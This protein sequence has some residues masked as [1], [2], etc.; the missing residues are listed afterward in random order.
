MAGS[1]KTRSEIA[2][3][4][5]HLADPS[6]TERMRRHA[7]GILIGIL[8][9]HAPGNAEGADDAAAIVE[10]ALP[11]LLEAYKSNQGLRIMGSLLPELVRHGQ[12][13]AVGATFIDE[14]VKNLYTDQY[15]ICTDFLLL[16]VEH[17]QAQL[18]IDRAGEAIANLWW[19]SNDTGQEIAGSLLNRL[20]KN[21]QNEAVKALMMPITLEYLKS[22]DKN[23]IGRAAIF[24][25]KLGLDNLAEMWRTG[26]HEAAK[27]ALDYLFANVG[28]RYDRGPKN[29]IA[30]RMLGV[31]TG[32]SGDQGNSARR[33]ALV[34]AL[35]KNGFE[36]VKD[37]SGKVLVIGKDRYGGDE[38][39]GYGDKW[40]DTLEPV[41]GIFRSWRS[42]ATTITTGRWPRRKHTVT[43][44]Q[45]TADMLKM[46]RAAVT[47]IESAPAKTFNTNRKQLLA[48]ALDNAQ[49]SGLSDLLPGPK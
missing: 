14:A 37:E 34:G 39:F 48:K 33:E 3:C 44:D 25:G 29:V 17:G 7:V 12:A 6:S 41:T 27:P 8:E 1:E 15:S 2:H 20:L 23:K 40:K 5:A 4:L 43:P 28:S 13:A 9:K 22:D 35:E 10:L 26:D 32:F 47:E 24:V 31:V 30:A 46:V 38:L 19:K 36:I 11:Q 42:T 21:G 16:L 49:Q 45:D 18:V